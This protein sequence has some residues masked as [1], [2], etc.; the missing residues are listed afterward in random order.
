M[1][2]LLFPISRIQNPNAESGIWKTGITSNRQRMIQGYKSKV[3]RVDY[4]NRYR[5]A[6]VIKS[7][8]EERHG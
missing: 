4:S 8:L 2:V 6:V 1:D 5:I 7:L 3:L